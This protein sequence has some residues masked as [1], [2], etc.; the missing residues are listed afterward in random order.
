MAA[1]KLAPIAETTEAI[2][3][4]PSLLTEATVDEL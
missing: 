4:P 2:F 3:F 1:Q